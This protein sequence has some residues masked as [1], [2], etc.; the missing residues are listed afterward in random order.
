MARQGGGEAQWWQV[1]YHLLWHFGD[2]QCPTRRHLA[3]LWWPINQLFKNI[4]VLQV[5]FKADIWINS[6]KR[7]LQKAPNALHENQV[8]NLTWIASLQVFHTALPMKAMLL[9]YFWYFI[10][11]SGQD[12]AYR[13]LEQQSNIISGQNRI[14]QLESHII[15]QP[16][17]V[18]LSMVAT[19]RCRTD[20]NCPHLQ[21]TCNR[22]I[23]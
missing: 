17:C 20:N 19:L 4:D 13:R 21:R 9:S 14:F 12:T 23:T 22:Y 15:L 10:P 5:N 18:H 8:K 16:W 2:S 11:G 3:S 1:C 7:N 6:V